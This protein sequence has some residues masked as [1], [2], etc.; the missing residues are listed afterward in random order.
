MP[1]ATVVSN[2][3]FPNDT[4]V[5][6]SMKND[7]FENILK[8]GEHIGVEF[9]RAQDGVKDDT[10]ETICSFLNR[11]GGDIFLGVLDNGDVVGVPDGAVQSIIKNVINVTNNPHLLNPTFYVYPEPMKF[12]GRNVIR[13][14]VPQSSEVHRFKGV[15]YDRVFESDVQVKSSYQIAEMYIR[16]RDVFTERK[17]FPFLR[18]EHLKM[19]LLP[20]IRNLI[21]SKFAAHPWLKLDD[22]QLLSASG[23]YEEDFVTGTR[24]FNAAAVLLLG[25]DEVI[26]NCFPAYKTDAIMKRVNT[27]RYDDRETVACNLVEAYDHLMAFGAKHLPDKFHL[28]DSTRISLRDKILREVVGNLLMHREFSSAKPARLV[29][30]RNRM[31]ADNAS[32]ALKCGPI[33]PDNLSPISKQSSQDSSNR[34]AVPTN[35]GPARKISTTT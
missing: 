1:L 30:E 18:T 4:S 17:P 26:F 29:I 10:F 27:E 6:T 31:V 22:N 2:A 8:V 9:K 32:K 19:D 33:T 11:F 3:H 15:C 21:Y 35:S 12:R 13:I 14:H 25:R 23:L 7:I 16:K 28:E 24:S 5:G 20:M 34:W